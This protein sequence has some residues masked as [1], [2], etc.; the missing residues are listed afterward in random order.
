MSALFGAGHAGAAPLLVLIPLALA[1]LALIVVC[2][3]SLVRRPVAAVRF[4]TKWPWVL[5]IVLVNWIGPI[6][7]LAVGRIDAPL[8]DRPGTSE[9][10]AADRAR[11]ATDLLYGPRDTPPN[12]S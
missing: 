9:T 8:P 7:Y 2:L 10:P 3:V 5:L 12:A 11:T 6:V 4:H 1:D